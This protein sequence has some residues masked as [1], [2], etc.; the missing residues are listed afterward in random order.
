M[1]GHQ[2][3]QL[4]HATKGGNATPK[5]ARTGKDLARTAS[6]ITQQGTEP[7]SQSTSAQYQQT[8]ADL[9]YVTG[10]CAILPS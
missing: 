5:A 8:V 9:Q 10:D 1:F 6:L 4:S 2:L 3:G 7:F